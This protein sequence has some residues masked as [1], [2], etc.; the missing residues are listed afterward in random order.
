MLPTSVTAATVKPFGRVFAEF[1][2]LS[3]V[4]TMIRKGFVLAESQ[5]FTENVLKLIKT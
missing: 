2:S 1:T 3:S 4:L 5:G